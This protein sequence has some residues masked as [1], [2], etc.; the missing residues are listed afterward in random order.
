MS[1]WKTLGAR[2][3]IVDFSNQ[4][5][6][7]IG[8]RLKKTRIMPVQNDQEDKVIQIQKRQPDSTVSLEQYA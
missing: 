4:F 7:R 3:N 1:W 2:S 8:N 6:E 5:L